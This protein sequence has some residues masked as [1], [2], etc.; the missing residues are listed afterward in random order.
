METVYEG[1]YVRFATVS[2]KD[3]AILLGADTIVGDSFTVSLRVEKG[4]SV[5]WLTNRFGTDTGYLDSEATRMVQLAEARGWTT[6]ALLS[7]VAYSDSP[8]PGEYWGEMA[9]FCY[10]PAY[11]AEFSAFAR[12]LSDRLSESVRPDISL[13]QQGIGKVLETKGEWLPS[14]T[15]PLPEKQTGTVIMKSRR[16]LSEKLI[17]QG[18]KGNIG[19]YVFGWAFILALVALAIFGLKQVGLF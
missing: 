8:D 15:V 10:D 14:S 6:R 12:A 11:E 5:A 4:S 19:C 17:E 2:K 18:R 1:R 9:L 3:A 7:F 13:S 16:S